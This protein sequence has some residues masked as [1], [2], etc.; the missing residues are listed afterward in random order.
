MKLENLFRNFT[1]KIPELKGMNYW[2]RLNTLK[3]KGILY[4]WKI[5]KGLVPNFGLEFSSEEIRRGTEVIIPKLKEKLRS[6]R[7][8]SFQIHCGKFFNSM[9][10][11][12]R[13]MAGNDLKDF[14]ENW[15][16]IF[17][18]FLM[19]QKQ[20]GTGY[21]PSSSDPITAKASNSLL[22]QSR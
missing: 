21:T 12:L 11:Y 15:T 2:E 10:K 4:A 5:L 7:E 20:M 8:Q 22:F 9:P 17:N 3:V 16:D 19:C 18:L 14:K 1:R 6:T 13:N